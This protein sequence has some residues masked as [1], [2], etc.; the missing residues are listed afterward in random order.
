MG[1]SKV[2][3]IEKLILVAE[4]DKGAN[5]NDADIY[6]FDS[7]DELISFRNKFPEKMKM[8][9]NYVYSDRVINS[10]YHAIAQ[11]SHFKQF[12]KAVLVIK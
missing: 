1:L 8:S 9:Y 3:K 4:W 5:L 2:I 6:Q 12:K 11:K 7:L 10:N